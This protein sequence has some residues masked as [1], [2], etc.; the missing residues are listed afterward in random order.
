MPMAK[1]ISLD[2]ALRV[3]IILFP[4]K[5]KTMNKT[6]LALVFL[7]SLSF[8][9][10]AAQKG[11]PKK[12]QTQSESSDQ[13]IDD[14]S[15]SG[16]N[17]R[18]KKAWEVKG[19]SADIF[20][21][22]VKLTSV[23]ANVYGEEEDVNLVADNGAYDKASGKMHLEDNVVITTTGGGKMTTDY[24][25]WDKESQRVSTEA[26]VNIEK[27]NIKATAKGLEGEPNLKR[28]SLKD[29]VKVEIREQAEALIAPLPPL[30]PQAASA[31]ES[32]IPDPLFSAKEPTIINC[33]GPLEIDYEKEI[34][35]FHNNVMVDQKDQGIMYADRMDAYF[36][37]KNKKILRI[38]SKGN[39][40]IVKDENTSYS[41]EALYSAQDGKLT[42]SGNPR[43][44]INSKD[45]ILNVP[46]E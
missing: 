4:K 34:A 10:D 25:D 28:I 8:T 17:Q 42:L 1:A 5:P 16:G 38:I 2:K 12:N 32:K 36:D 22:V 19:K 7:F 13:R 29:N 44:V 15:L 27:Q 21:D 26:M 31:D 39:V 14:F 46:S 45:K 43:L 30:A 40:K 24:L 20:T 41:D 11:A 3:V 18:G 37:F 35:I 33:S 9:L 23:N 6:V